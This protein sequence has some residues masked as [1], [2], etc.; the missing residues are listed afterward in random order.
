VKIIKF[1][2][3]LISENYLFDHNLMPCSRFFLVIYKKNNGECIMMKPV[4]NKLTEEFHGKLNFYSI[5]YIE[6]KD[7][8]KLYN[9]EIAPC[10]LLF[11]NGKPI[12]IMYGL[13]PC[14][15]LKLFIEKNLK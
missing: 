14:N 13:S 5:D 11:A 2:P 10:F 3:E 15:E 9:I 6:S 1:E 7:I 8:R 12:E 4:I